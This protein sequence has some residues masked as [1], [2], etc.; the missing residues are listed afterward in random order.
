MGAQVLPHSCSRVLKSFFFL[1]SF[2]VFLSPFASSID[3]SSNFA[4]VQLLHRGLGGLRG[5]RGSPLSLVGEKGVMMV[6]T[7]VKERTKALGDQSQRSR[8]GAVFS[9]SVRPSVSSLQRE[10][11]K[12]AELA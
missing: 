5:W 11:Q 10:R 2:F 4:E 8:L 6:E 9:T 12:R 3:Y 7:T 1:F